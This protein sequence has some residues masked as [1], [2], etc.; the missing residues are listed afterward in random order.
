MV[1]VTVYLHVCLMVIFIKLVE[2]HVTQRKLTLVNVGV[3]ESK[4]TEI[5]DSI[6]GCCLTGAQ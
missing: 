5:I 2:R 3:I 4:Y 6:Q 1:N